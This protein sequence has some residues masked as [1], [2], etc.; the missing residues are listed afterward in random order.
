MKVEK[1]RRKSKH[2]LTS[3]K[4]EII[5]VE[6]IAGKNVQRTIGFPYEQ[7]IP[8][9]TKPQRT[10]AKSNV[11]GVK[12]IIT[13]DQLP[14]ARRQKESVKDSNNHNGDKLDLKDRAPRFN[15]EHS[16]DRY[17]APE[18]WH[19]VEEQSHKPVKMHVKSIKGTKK[20]KIFDRTG[21]RIDS[22]TPHLVR[23][24]STE[25]FELADSNQTSNTANAMLAILA[26]SSEQK[27]FK[28]Q[29]STSSAK[30]R[31]KQSRL[32]NT[33]GPYQD[34]VMASSIPLDG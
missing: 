19:K 9:A 33:N 8:R 18:L 1:H 34:E 23:I 13:A 16:N 3:Y 26:Q 27:R 7:I 11:I 25:K 32:T 14:K 15:S 21:V 12:S 20:A 24:N 30:G 10:L 4:V 31:P 6:N 29:R 2:Q 5:D 28:K 22:H 17:L